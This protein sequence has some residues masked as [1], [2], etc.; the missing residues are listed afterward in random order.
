MVESLAFQTK[1]RTVDHLGREQI[2]DCPTAI[3]ELWKNAYDAYARNVELSIFDGVEPV[4]VMVDDGHGMSREEFVSRWLV[5]GTA[6]K[7]ASA[8]PPP[9]DMNGLLP[10]PKQGQKGIGRLSSANLGPLLLLVSKRRTSK[11]VAALIDWRLFENPYLNLSDIEIPLIEFTSKDELFPQLPSMFSRLLENIDGDLQTDR[12]QRITAAWT[13]YDALWREQAENAR[14]TLAV[15]SAK[16]R[17]SIN[18]AV[19]EEDHIARWDAWN[20]RSTS[21]TA[22]LIS[23]INFDLKAFLNIHEVDAAAKGARQRFF[24]TLSSFVDPFLDVKRVDISGVDPGFSYSVKSWQRG[25]GSPNSRTPHTIVG[26][27]KEFTRSMIEPMEHIIDGFINIHGVF[28]GRVKSF[29]EWRSEEAVILPPDDLVVPEGYEALLGPV[30]LF[31]ASMEFTSANTTHAPAEYHR[32]KELAQQY[33]GFMVFRDGLR[34]LPYGR[35]DNDFF[36]I[37]MRRSKNAGREFWNQRQMFGRL[38]ISRKNNPNLKDKA[39]REGLLDNRAAKTLK[40]LISNVLM[41]SARQYFGSNSEY[42]SELL[43]EIKKINAKNKAAEDRKKVRAK[44]RTNFQENLK[45]FRGQMPALISALE[46]LNNRSTISSEKEIDEISQ[47]LSEIKEKRSNFRLGAIPDQLGPLENSY[48]H[49]KHDLQRSQTLISAL[50]T[51]IENAAE[52]ILNS[53][54]VAA[55]ERQQSRHAGQL[56]RRIRTWKSRIEELQRKEYDRTRSLIDQRNKIF[57]AEMAPMLERLRNGEVPISEVFKTMQKVSETL[58]EENE[59]LFVPYI[60]AL[61]SLS[62]SIDLEN[63]AT[64]GMEEVSELRT[65]LERLNSLAQ[66]GITVEVVG[67]DLEDYDQIIGAALGQLSEE[68]KSLKPIKDIEFAFAGLTDQ[69]RFLS[70]L[71]LSGHRRQEWV[72]GQVI[73]D[74][75]SRFFGPIMARS[76]IDFTATDAFKA[77]RVYDQP[78]RL[79]PVFI[80][81]VNNS[82]YWVSTDREKEKRIILDAIGDRV[83]VSDNGPGVNSED[84]ENLFTLFFSKKSRGG[85]GVGLYLCR[86]NLAAG[87]HSISYDKVKTHA[88][89]DGANFIINFRGAEFIHG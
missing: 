32:F 11:F 54:P 84:W 59:N 35:E 7:V 40:I 61:E 45:K 55:A 41:Q 62:E 56:H 89:L 37:E 10:R 26:T 53:N 82:R 33:A 25:N 60:S 34:V 19:F 17:Q 65:E 81:L 69:L 47:S 18:K 51:R 63:L 8:S 66:L 74:Y 5:V 27:G 42:R 23:Q 31:I 20:G 52:Q 80:N 85:R 70:P 24:E 78:S 50:D 58:D 49:F 43:P 4:A 46:E 87:G 73:W 68:V 15:P 9:D 71:K 14:T 88:P 28:K 36:E 83:Y 67:H 75:V 39:G 16:I 77:F 48:S 12:G 30:D 76:K 1:A 86:A 57:H 29:G 44:L 3:S 6:S 22:M 21:G 13:D 2:A 64:F 79:Y 38:A 72:T